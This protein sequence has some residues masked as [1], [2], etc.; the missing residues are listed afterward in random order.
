[1]KNFREASRDITAEYQYVYDPTHEHKPRGTWKMTGSG[2]SS[3]TDGKATEYT[4]IGVND[5][6][7]K[8]DEDE[9]N[10]FDPEELEP[11]D[12]DGD[13]D[14][15]DDEAP[16]KPAEASENKDDDTEDE[17]SDENKEDN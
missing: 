2:W 11:V 9:K 6:E 10:D 5:D 3:N 17:K 13:V 1:M 8:T 16:A 12:H 4:E 14:D 15:D 7:F